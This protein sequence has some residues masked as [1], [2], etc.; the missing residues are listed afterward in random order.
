MADLRVLS[1][2]DAFKVFEQFT[3]FALFHA[4][5]P[6]DVGSYYSNGLVLRSRDYFENQARQIF[7]GPQNP[8][9][10][11]SKLAVA[12]EYSNKWSLDRIYAVIDDVDLLNHCG[13]YF[14]YGSEFLCGIGAQLSKN[15]SRDYRQVLKNIGTPTLFELHVPTDAL[16]ETQL[17]DLITHLLEMSEDLE[18]DQEYFRLDWSF[19]FQQD[20]PADWVI[21]HSHPEVIRDP[22]SR[23]EFRWRDSLPFIPAN[24]CSTPNHSAEVS[25]P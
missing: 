17:T 8:E 7:L 3:H 12:L 13:H 19:I 2:S 25:K 20:I 5:R 10:T 21:S 14:I 1:E 23:K 18:D 4:C 11:E 24:E 15:S 16:P 6:V 22:Y 9:I